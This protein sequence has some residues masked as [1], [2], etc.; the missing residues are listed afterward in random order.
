MTEGD[1]IGMVGWAICVAVLL[2]WALWPKLAGRLPKR[3]ARRSRKLPEWFE[4]G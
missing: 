4:L 1:K 2:A 3:P